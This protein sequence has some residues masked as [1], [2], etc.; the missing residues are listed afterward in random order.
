V[1]QSS[2][3]CVR[4]CVCTVLYVWLTGVQ[5]GLWVRMKWYTHTR[6]N[7]CTFLYT[8]FGK[9]SVYESRLSPVTCGHN[10]PLSYN[11]LKY[12]IVT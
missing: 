8:M 3:T 7:M 12:S 2:H 4:V 11:G 6:E 1:L 9:L 5:V 10:V